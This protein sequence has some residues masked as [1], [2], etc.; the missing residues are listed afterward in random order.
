[1][2]RTNRVPL[3]AAL[4]LL[5]TIIPLIQ[6]RLFPSSQ[7]L[8]GIQLLLIAGV[9]V[10][11]VGFLCAGWP[12]LLE[13]PSPHGTRL[14][15]A[16]TGIAAIAVSLLTSVVHANPDPPASF[17]GLALVVA[18]SVLAAFIH[19]MMRKQRDRLTESLTG[20]IC[21]ALIVTLAIGWI[22]AARF[23]SGACLTLAAGASFTAASLILTLPMR[24]QVLIPMAL[25]GG[26]AVGTLMTAV[27]RPGALTVALV[28]GLVVAVLTVSIHYL[29][30]RVYR[31]DEPRAVL[32]TAAAP[33]AVIGFVV[34]AVVGIFGL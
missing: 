14:V 7:M 32:T 34:I 6:G 22:E 21:G 4:G 13:L 17:T 3:G 5:I 10:I 29:L 23:P 20:T 30:T 27:T 15:M 28:T 12:E 8:S 31:A 19:E 2:P 33:V 9:C 16:C 25:V 1:M 18:A 26:T 24:G 11:V